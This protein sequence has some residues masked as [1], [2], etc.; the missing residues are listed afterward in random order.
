MDR[1]TIVCIL[2]C[3]LL[4]SAGRA[5]NISGN[6]AL[7]SIIKVALER[8][9]AVHAAEY[10]HSAF[11]HQA[12][13]AGWLPDPVLTAGILNL[14]R[15]SL[16]LDETPMS[17]V[18]LGLSQSIPWPGK[19]SARAGIARLDSDIRDMDLAAHR[20][21]IIRQV[22]HHYYD[23]SHWMLV[24]DILTESM[25]LVENIT[26]VAQT[27]YSTGEG[28]LQDVLSAET[29]RARIENRILM[30]RQK[31]SS[32]L[33]QLAHLTDNPGPM[34]TSVTPALPPIPLN[35]IQIPV[36]LSNPILAKASFGSAVARRKLDLAKSQ[37]WPNLTVGVDYRIRKDMPMDAVSGEDFLSFKVGLNLPMWFFARQRN[38]SAAARQLYNAAQAE[39]AAIRNSVKQQ[40]ADIVLILQS[41]RQRT[42]QYESTILPQ[43]Q[44]A[45][46]A[47]RVAYEVGKVDFNGFLS[48]QLETINVELERLELLKQY[49]QQ[50]AALDELTYDTQ[51]VI[52]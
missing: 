9:P 43:A 38:Q 36:E 52:K 48:A 35:E 12:K 11:E 23:Y 3:L 8:N 16:R 34:D 17:G 4:V 50:K 18:S 27:R 25:Q 13:F 39:E 20:N 28:V 19:S 33:V 40:V 46:E 24:A 45:G 7:D 21:S 26:Q 1:N 31:A 22:T 10:R 51:E 5:D 44:A 29:S 6:H 47:A 32:A 2:L 37:Y 14:P 41:L 42:E 30:A 15:T 49:H